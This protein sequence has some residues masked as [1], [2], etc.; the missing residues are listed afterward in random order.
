MEETQTPEVEVTAS[1]SVAETV[2][3]TTGT[4]SQEVAE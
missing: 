1:E 2:S 4:P 3:E